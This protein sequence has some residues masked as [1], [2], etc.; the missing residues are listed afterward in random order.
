MPSLD[1]EA[2]AETSEMS[3]QGSDPVVTE[4]LLSDA[5]DDSAQSVRPEEGVIAQHEPD[6]AATQAA[7]PASVISPHQAATPVSAAAAEAEDAD[8]PMTDADMD[9][10]PLDLPSAGAGPAEID[11]A[12]AGIPLQSTDGD[13]AHTPA[14]PQ[15]DPEP[16]VAVETPDD[17]AAPANPTESGLKAK[18][19]EAASLEASDD[20]EE[21][22]TRTAEDEGAEQVD[23]PD[24]AGEAEPVVDP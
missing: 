22:V 16:A 20:G 19:T 15:S 5:V 24:V 2:A 11:L 14:M 1:P 6:S 4:V 21:E 8:R 17:V 9:H 18:S 23:K 7:S 3:S 13:V 10:T 12:D